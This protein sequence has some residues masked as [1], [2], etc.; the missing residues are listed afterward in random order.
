[1]TQKPFDAAAFKARQER[2]I[3]KSF[4]LLAPTAITRKVMTALRTQGTVSLDDLIAAFEADVANEGLL[5]LISANRAALKQLQDLR[6][7][8]PDEANLPA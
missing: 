1:M 3:Q 7:E 8:Q 5:H 2:Q 4:E 6:Q